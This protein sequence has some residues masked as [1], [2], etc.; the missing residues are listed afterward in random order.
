MSKFW[1]GAL[2]LL[3][4]GSGIAQGVMTDLLNPQNAVSAGT[5]QTVVFD[6]KPAVLVEKPAPA[7]APKPEPVPQMTVV[8]PFGQVGQVP[9]VTHIADRLVRV[10]ILDNESVWV[11]DQVLAVLTQ[12][13]TDWVRI[14]PKQVQNP[15]G[16]RIA[17]TR[18]ILGVWND[19]KPVAYTVQEDADSV[20][21]ALRKPLNKGA[22][23]LVMQQVITGVIQK[24][25]SVAEVF[26]PVGGGEMPLMTE[27]FHLSVALPRATKLYD[28]SLLFGGNNQAVA[29]YEVRAGTRDL[30]FET[31]HI[32]PAYTDV[33]L[34][35]VSEAD[36]IAVA[37]GS[38]SAG[39]KII[40]SVYAGILALYALALVLEGRRRRI[41]N[42]MRAGLRR[43]V[44]WWASVSGVPVS[45]ADRI[46]WERLLP[47]KLRPWR[48]GGALRVGVSRWGEPVAGVVLLILGTLWLA[49]LHTIILSAGVMAWMVALGI[50]TVMIVVRLG[51]REKLRR[52]RLAF[53]QELLQTPAG[54][55]PPAGRVG[56]YYA[57][58]MSLGIGDKWRRKV[59]E[60][61]PHYAR[62]DFW[63]KETL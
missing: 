22:H 49:K 55:C 28:K 23:R 60:C 50:G 34:R 39:G 12:D 30:L 25:K 41:K 18:Q 56:V 46:L 32:L 4:A 36:T 43:N 2:I 6:G 33:R 16:K 13:K 27:Q 35:L 44:M 38:G 53:C 54:L 14:L 10:Q 59:L 5:G 42:P 1:V 26:V 9:Y 48:R 37:A 51:A 21:V 8:A 7:P 63:K 45:E 24:N 11:E 62:L 52:M 31:T 15:A 17:M 58:A 3:W 57:Y 61:N 20:Q 47:D 29:N 40:I 19:G